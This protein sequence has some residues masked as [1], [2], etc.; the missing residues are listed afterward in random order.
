MPF[1]WGGLVFYLI[2]GVHAI[3]ASYSIYGSE[4]IAGSILAMLE[5]PVY[6]YASLDLCGF[7]LIFSY[8]TYQDLNGNLKRFWFWPILYYLFGT[9]AVMIYFLYKKLILKN[10]DEI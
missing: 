7:A 4:W 8:A 5:D 1:I 2:V 9:P 6:R 3:H 10:E